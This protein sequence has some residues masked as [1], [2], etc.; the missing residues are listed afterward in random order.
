MTLF[1]SDSAATVTGAAHLVNIHAG[2]A[3]PAA[4]YV[5]IAVVAAAV[6]FY[7]VVVRRHRD[8]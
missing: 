2:Q 5:V 3:L 1:L 6:T 8:R 7:V 4:R